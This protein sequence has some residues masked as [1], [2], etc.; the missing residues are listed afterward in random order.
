M[1]NFD[2][3][4][5]LGKKV[6][7]I[8]EVGRGTLAGPVLAAAVFIDRSQWKNFLKRYPNII[9]IDDSKKISKKNRLRIYNA[10]TKII[11]FGIGAASVKEIEENNI[12]QASLKAMERAYN[13]LSIDAEFVLVDGIN[14][15]KINSKVKTIKNG[16]NIST[17]IASASIIAKVIR[18]KLMTKLSNKY[19]EFLWNKNSGYGTK[20]HIENIKIF[21]ITPHHRKTFKPI[22]KMVE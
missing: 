17:S 9:K 5:S 4:E 14:A 21:G 12:L 20:K 22:L 8:D 13:A 11:S 18:D 7:G 16:D 3:E 19:P 15:P 2:I 10:L 6:I 1:T